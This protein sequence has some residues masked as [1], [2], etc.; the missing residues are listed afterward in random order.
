VQGWCCPR[1]ECRAQR[2]IKLKLRAKEVVKKYEEI[3]NKSSFYIDQCDMAPS[4]R[5]QM[6]HWQHGSWSSITGPLRPQFHKL[7]KFAT[8][9]WLLPCSYTST[10]EM[11]PPGN[12]SKHP[13]VWVD[14]ALLCLMW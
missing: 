9:H 3:Y 8:F 5:I 10:W 11:Q 1:R 14:M 13:Y 7:K 6:L 2:Y 12:C 4:F